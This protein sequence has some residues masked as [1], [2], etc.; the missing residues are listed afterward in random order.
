MLLETRHLYTY[1]CIFLNLAVST[2]DTKRPKNMKST[3]VYEIH[4]H[5][6]HTPGAEHDVYE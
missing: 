4:D 3:A 1:I 5:K 2:L 6:A